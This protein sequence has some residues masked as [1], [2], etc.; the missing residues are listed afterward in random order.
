ME[1]KLNNLNN[2]HHTYD[3]QIPLA[4]RVAEA[5]ELVSNPVSDRGVSFF[6]DD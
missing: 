1:M 5:I 4:Q 2:M 3:A 6:T